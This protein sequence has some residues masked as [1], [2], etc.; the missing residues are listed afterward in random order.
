[1]QPELLKELKLGRALFSQHLQA[2]APESDLPWKPQQGYMEETRNGDCSSAFMQLH[3]LPCKDVAVFLLTQETRRNRGT[4]PLI[5]CECT[6]GATHRGNSWVLCFGSVADQNLIP[7]LSDFLLRGWG[8]GK[9]LERVIYS[10]QGALIVFSWWI[11]WTSKPKNNW[12]VPSCFS[13]PASSRRMNIPWIPL[14]D[15]RTPPL[16]QG[17]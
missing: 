10:C 14:V 9:V 3:M 5:E 16:G 15:S 1:M 17:S 12:N 8:S 4:K 2:P 7:G 13:W 6:R 11:Y